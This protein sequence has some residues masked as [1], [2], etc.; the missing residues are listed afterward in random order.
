MDI[1]RF[2]EIPDEPG[3]SVFLWGPRKT[4]KSTW[5]RQQLHDHVLIDLLAS[6]TYYDYS[7]RPQLLRERAEIWLQSKPSW[8]VLDEVQ[9][10]PALLNEVHWLIENRGARFLLTGSSARKLRR[11]QANLLGGRAWRREMRPLCLAELG[12]HDWSL[13]SLVFSGL[14][15]AHFL[16][17]KPQEHLRAYVSDYLKEEIAAEALTRNLPAFGEFLR[18]SALSNGELLNLENLAREVAVSARAIA[19]YFDILQDTLIGERLPAW[20]RSP[21]R[22]LIKTDKFYFFDVGVANFL[23]RRKPRAGTPEFGKSLEH[24]VWMELRA[25]QAYRE[26]DLA[27][28]FW[29]SAS[30]FEVDFLLGE[31]Q[32]AIEVKSGRVHE[33]DLKGLSA[34]SDDAPVQSRIIVCLEKEAKILNDR[35][36]PVTCLPLAQFVE[37]LW[38]GE[39]IT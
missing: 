17:K 5:I 21:N 19:N 6:E 14:L 38:A 37:R 8:I 13:E 35:H 23:A 34:F 33:T 4:G 24:L 39:L 9:R 11:G 22:R 10:I 25:F 27:M 30:G 15:P 20:T 2:L 36:G 3:Q 1:Q 7:T 28:A 32:L 29:R 18:V 26:P 12:E 31:R 16:A